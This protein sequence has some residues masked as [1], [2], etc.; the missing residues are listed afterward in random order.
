MKKVE[1]QYM[2]YYLQIKHVRIQITFMK[3]LEVL[4]IVEK[5]YRLNIKAK[6]IHHHQ[7][8]RFLFVLGQDEHQSKVN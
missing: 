1:L 6:Q 2:I 3:K 5:T 7:V 4:G 8:L